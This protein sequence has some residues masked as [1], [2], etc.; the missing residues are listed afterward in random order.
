[1]CVP[2]PRRPSSPREA[3]TARACP[4]EEGHC[5]NSAQLYEEVLGILGLPLPDH[6]YDFKHLGSEIKVVLSISGKYSNLT[7]TY[8][9]YPQSCNVK[10]SEAP[11]CATPG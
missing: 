8:H 5:P 2:R 9:Q 3:H 7:A 10:V 4:G 1:M 11:C 6:A